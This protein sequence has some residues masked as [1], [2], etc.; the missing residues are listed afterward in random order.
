MKTK[1]IFSTKV[2]RRI[3][4]ILP[5]VVFALFVFFSCGKSNGPDATLTEVAPPPPPPPVAVS[6][7]AYVNVDELPLFTGGDKALLSYIANNTKYPSD[8]KLKGIQGKVVVRLIVRK[9]GSVSDV[10]ILKGVTP[11]LD[12]EAIRVVS[13]LPKFEA[14]GKLAGVPVAVKYM[15]PITFTLQ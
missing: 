9:D 14:P 12:A 5:I 7:S 8:A 1:E 10:N 6:D 2:N 3:Y 15:I 13:S 11:S 4:L